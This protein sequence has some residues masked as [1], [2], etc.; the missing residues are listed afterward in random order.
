MQGKRQISILSR[1]FVLM[2]ASA[3]IWNAPAAADLV[4]A[5]SD[6]TTD[7]VVVDQG[8]IF[9]VSSDGVTSSAA[10]TNPVL[11]GVEFSGTI[12]SF[13]ITLTAG[14]S[15]PVIGPGK[16]DLFSLTVSGGAGGT[17]TVAV[18]DD[19]FLAPDPAPGELFTFGGTTDGVVD[20]WSIVDPDDLEFSTLPG[21]LAA[22]LDGAG[23]SIEMADGNE[24]SVHATGLTGGPFSGSIA[25]GFTPAIAAPYAMTIVGIITHANPGDITSFNAHQAIIPEPSSLL[26][27]GC[28]IVVFAVFTQVRRRRNKT[29]SV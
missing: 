24:Q 11:G 15:K 28:G 9:A 13:I 16:I 12:G 5:I 14:V 7:I 23:V 27:L 17:L 10:D 1:I 29:Q 2:A 22:I 8:G 19:E 18:T 20:L 6:G 21:G 4:I 25:T 26:L 3:M